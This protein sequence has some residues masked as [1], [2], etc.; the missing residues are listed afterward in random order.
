VTPR[1]VPLAPGE[2]PAGMRDALAAL[3]PPKPRHPMPE[4]RDDR[5]KGLNILGLLAHHPDLARAYH[6]FTGHAL[7]ATT[8]SLRQRE[9][10]ILRVAASRDAEY[11][12]LQHKVIGGD[13]GLTPEEIARV[14]DGPDAEGWDPLDAA[15]V[16]AVD[17]LLA[18]A[19]IAEAT[20]AVLADALDA[21]QLLD[22]VFTV[23]AYDVLA[24]A[25]RTFGVEL[26]DDLTIWR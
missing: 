1:L 9:L 21:Q 22:V 5:P 10:V 15:L 16:R 3:T 17:E 12:W 6:G 23:G 19:C 11:E 24:M 7:F 18:D 8:L 26:D 14:G 2:W 13:V 4:R 20:Y 25:M